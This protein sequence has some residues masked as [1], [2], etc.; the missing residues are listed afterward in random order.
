LLNLGFV[1]ASEEFPAG[2]VFSEGK[3]VAATTPEPGTLGL[4][5]TGLVGIIGVIQRKRKLPLS[6]YKVRTLSRA[7]ISSRLSL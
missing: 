1:P 7:D 4:M 6:R 3:F 5:A 2:Y